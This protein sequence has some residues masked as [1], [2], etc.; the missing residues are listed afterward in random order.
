MCMRHII[1][2]A[3]IVFFLP[4]ITC[5]QDIIY[6]KIDSIVQAKMNE[7]RIQG[8]SISIIKDGR[9]YLTK[10]YGFTSTDKKYPVTENTNFLTA[11]ITKLFTA[12]AIM[13]LVDQGKLDLNKK[14]IDY[15]PDFK[16]KDR[17]FKEITLFHLLTHSSGLPWD[18]EFE[19]AN[20]DSSALKEFIFSL[21]NTKLKFSP[22]EKFNGETYSNTGYDIL[23][24]LVEQTASM[25]FQEYVKHF[26]LD[27]TG[28]ANSTFYL[29]NIRTDKLAYPLKISG[30]SK[31]INRFNLY[32]EIKDINPVLKYPEL[33]IVAWTNY[34]W[35]RSEHNPS[36]NLFSTASDLANW[37]TLCLATYNGAK[38]SV[39]NTTTLTKMW[40]LQRNIENKQT[41]IGL[42]WWRFTDSLKGNYV[43][44]V[45]RD[46]G[47]SS[48]LRIYPD[49]NIGITILTN[50]MYADQV[51]W[52]ELPELIIKLLNENN[53]R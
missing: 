43:F 6:H 28:M 27:K 20:R 40:A 42:G 8:L 4:K 10:G 23:G 26:I 52:N 45:G 38:N 35:G 53:G 18:N 37:M 11:S 30:D 47:Y 12:T 36:G 5:G 24:Y 16:L 13:Q 32:A 19:N 33:P 14:L 31:E 17:R 25:P 51:I 15:I 7:Y 46:P 21:S 50:A 29:K 2:N 9:N 39:L 34:Q 49:K 22:G 3:L 41:S 44:H 48:T 1:L